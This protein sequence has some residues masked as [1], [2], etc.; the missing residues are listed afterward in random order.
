MNNHTKIEVIGSGCKKCKTLFD[1]TQEVVKELNINTTVIYTIN[2][3]KIVAM[4]IMSSPVLTIDNNPVLIGIL[5]EKNR[6]KEIL[7]KSIFNISEKSQ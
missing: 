3:N 2:I 4:G 6:L 1:L 5:P 7:Y